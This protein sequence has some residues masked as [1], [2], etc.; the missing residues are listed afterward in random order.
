METVG[1]LSCM[2]YEDFYYWGL[3]WVELAIDWIFVGMAMEVVDFDEV[4]S[5]DVVEDFFENFVED[6]EENFVGNFEDKNVDMV[7]KMVDT[8]NMES[9]FHR[10]LVILVPKLE[11]DFEIGAKVAAKNSKVEVDY[12][13]DHEIPVFEVPA[14]VF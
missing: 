1:L 14:K 3:V 8:D 12:T 7:D 4:G 5:D 11:I 10:D 6:F 2:C 13:F 9:I